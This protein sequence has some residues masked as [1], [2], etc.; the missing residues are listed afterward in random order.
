MK[1]FQIHGFAIAMVAGLL[2]LVTYG[3]VSTG[4]YGAQYGGYNGLYYN[5]NIG[6]GYSNWGPNYFVGPSRRGEQG[7]DHRG[8]QRVDQGGHE[9]AHAYRA[10]PASHAMPSIPS[11]SRSGRSGSHGR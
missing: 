6:D 11:S 1:L 8:A 9:M 7:A 5:E 2:T 3:C 4:G 10:A